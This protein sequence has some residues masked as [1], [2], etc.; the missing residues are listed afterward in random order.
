M[1][2]KPRIT[3]SY[4]TQAVAYRGVVPYYQ[5]G[6]YLCTTP[7]EAYEA[8]YRSAYRKHLLIGYKS[9]ANRYSTKL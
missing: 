1:K 7:L 8:A 2:H 4:D 9:I 6:W 3:Q 5:L